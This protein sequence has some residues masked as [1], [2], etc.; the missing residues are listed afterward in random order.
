MTTKVIRYDRFDGGEFGRLGPEHAPKNSWTGRNMLVY[1]TGALGVRA[2]VEEITPDSFPSGAVHLISN[3]IGGSMIAV[4]GTAVRSFDSLTG[5]NLITGGTALASTASGSS[6]FVRD[7]GSIYLTVSGDKTYRITGSASVTAYASSPGG[8]AV[9]RYGARLLVAGESSSNVV[10]YSAADDFTS[11]PGNQF[12]VGDSSTITG[13]WVQ[14]DHLLISKAN[15]GLWVLSGAL[16]DDATAATL[17]EVAPNIAGP[18]NQRRGAILPN[19]QLI[20]SPADN[21][22]PALFNGTYDRIFEHLST[23]GGQVVPI[24]TAR[25][26]A[27]FTDGTG[28]TDP[29]TIVSMLYH[30][31]SWSLHTFSVF[32]T[33]GGV[34]VADY[35]QAVEGTD[36]GSF[37]V[38]CTIDSTPQFYV[39]KLGQDSPGLESDDY[40]RAGDASDSQVTGNFSLP[41]GKAEN[42]EEWIVRHVIVDGRSWDTGGSLTNHFDISVDAVRRY[43]SV[44]SR[45]SD[46]LSWDHDGSEFSTSGTPFSESFSFGDQGYGHAFQLHFANVRGVAID[47]ITVVVDVRPARWA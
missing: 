6:A 18:D 32:G 36:D 15:G 39:W 25:N 33:D 8:R 45:S 13:M 23:E 37:V 42:G 44:G 31:D 24:R 28:T 10:E 2:G 12:V 41:Y 7:N 38:F 46:T 27:L 34:R 3:P 11:W 40:Q 29:E 14:R 47:S 5:A 17:R 19:D 26:S 20:F 16:T 1:R 43:D 4:Q 35:P 9:A 22:N 21:L 30:R